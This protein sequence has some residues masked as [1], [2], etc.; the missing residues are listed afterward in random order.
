[1]RQDTLILVIPPERGLVEGFSSGVVALANYVRAQCVVATVRLLDLGL[2]EA[3]A[4]QEIREVLQQSHGRI[5]VGVTTT[6]ASYQSALK[7]VGIFKHFAPSSIII[8]GG[9]HASAQDEIILRA[10]PEIDIVI[11]G[12]GEVAL[13]SLISEYPGLSNI[14]NITYRE[15]SAIRRN[16]NGRFLNGIELDALAPNFEG[17]GLR[18]APGKIGH[19][20]YVSARGCPLRCSFCAVADEPIRAK[21]VKSIVADLRYLA[22]ELGYKDIAFEDNF[23]AHSPRRTLTVCEGIAGLQHELGFKWDCQTRVESMHRPDVVHAMQKA[24]C[25]GVYLGV[26][27]LARDHL[28]YLG[29]TTKPESYL[30]VL[31]ETVLPLL[32]ASKIECYFLLQ[33]GIPNESPETHSESLRVLT[34]VGR[35]ARSANKRILVFPHLHVIYPGTMHHMMALRSCAFG[36]LGK[37]VFESFTK[38]EAQNEPVLNWMGHTFGHGI[39]GIPMGIL[40]P[41]KLKQDGQF[42]V[43]ARAVLNISTYLREMEAVPGIEVFNYGPLLV[44][45]GGGSQAI[46]KSDSPARVNPQVRTHQAVSGV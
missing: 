12:E 16:A 34:R 8:L 19:I 21:S 5:F 36:P 44:Q 46:P 33:V 41:E 40:D 17:L 3:T 1:M 6:T 4:E 11:R 2:S 25:D 42:E 29:K 9:H 31:E 24:G 27:A 35:A 39:G 30:R 37:D 45:N 7:T 18:S 28:L 32:F 15:G 26:E 14:P 38:W 23:F 22:G 10:H 43:D 20:T 13:L